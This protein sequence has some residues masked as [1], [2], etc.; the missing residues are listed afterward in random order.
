M[1][2]PNIFRSRPQIKRQNLHFDHYVIFSHVGH[3]SWQAD[4]FDIFATR[5]F[6]NACKV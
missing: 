5:Y 4:S 2:K 6:N 3:L 1:G